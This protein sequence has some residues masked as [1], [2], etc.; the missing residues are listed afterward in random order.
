[1]CY[2]AALFDWMRKSPE[3]ELEILRQTEYRAGAEGTRYLREK[4]PQKVSARRKMWGEDG[5][6]ARLLLS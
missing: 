6:D 2:S 4:L 1:M 5:N 3:F